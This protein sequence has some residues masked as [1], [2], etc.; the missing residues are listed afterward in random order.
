M[1]A[2]SLASHILHVYARSE[3]AAKED[4]EQESADK[5]AAAG[6]V[7]EVHEVIDRADQA[8]EYAQDEL[9]RIDRELRL[10]TGGKYDE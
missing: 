3:E 7:K 10:A 1:K 9:A 5:S 6:A 4:A 2:H 8:L